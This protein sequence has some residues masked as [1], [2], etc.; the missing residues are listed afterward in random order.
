MRERVA[1]EMWMNSV[2]SSLFRSSLY[3]ISDTRFCHRPTVAKPEFRT[4]AM[5]C[6]MLWPLRPPCSQSAFCASG[7]LPVISASYGVLTTLE[8]VLGQLSAAP[9]WE[10]RNGADGR[11]RTDGLLFTK[12]LL[13][14]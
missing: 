8:R 6:W 12:Q 7:I 10:L 3:H 5:R 4:T 2:E 11:I 1:K 14:H 13:C 9:I